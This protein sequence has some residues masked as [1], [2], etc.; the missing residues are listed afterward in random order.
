MSHISPQENA[1]RYA[2]SALMARGKLEIDKRNVVNQPSQPAKPANSIV[3]ETPN[4]IL[5][6]T[7]RPDAGSQRNLL[8]LNPIRILSAFHLDEIPY[9]FRQVEEALD[10]G[11]YVASFVSYE[12]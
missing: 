6:Q 11:S 3:A 5:L 1:A 10:A 2:T 8:L 12:C 4:S 7:S 9:L